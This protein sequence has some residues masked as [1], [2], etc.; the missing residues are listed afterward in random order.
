VKAKHFT[1]VKYT[2]SGDN[3]ERNLDPN[4]CLG[5]VPVWAGSQT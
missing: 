4:V 1:C 5:Y 2:A 3:G